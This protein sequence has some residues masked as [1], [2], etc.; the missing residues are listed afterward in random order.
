MLLYKS[1]LYDVN[2]DIILFQK[3]AQEAHALLEKLGPKV[4]LVS[5]VHMLL[6][7]V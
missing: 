3:K 1:Q 5:H 4:E 6:L 2:E 7:T